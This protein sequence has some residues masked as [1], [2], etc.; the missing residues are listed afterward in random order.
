MVSDAQ[1]RHELRRHLPRSIRQRNERALR[2]I[3]L[4]YTVARRQCRR[5]PEDADDMLQEST[6]GLIKG[7]E[8][9]DP[10]RGLK[11]SSYLISLATGQIL[12]YRR[13]RAGTVRIP[14]RLRDLYVRG[15]RLQE[16]R[17]HVGLQPL[18]EDDLAMALN[19][20]LKRWRD[21]VRANACRTVHSL[22]EADFDQLAGPADDPHL[23]W[24]RGALLQLDQQH[25]DL[26]VAHWIDGRSVQELSSVQS[27][28]ASK[29]RTRLKTAIAQLKHWAK[30]DG[31]G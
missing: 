17:R 11:P 10:E 13:D 18:A 8:R 19:I 3:G 5:G 30:R 16:H 25:R 7:I 23:N 15:Q 14:W 2:H 27:M 24:L 22:D 26:I 28:T 4:A 12:H 21:A 29:I 1:R 6:L 9:F 31:C 20:N